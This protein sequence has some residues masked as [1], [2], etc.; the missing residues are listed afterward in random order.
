MT[1]ADM[2]RS[3]EVY[4]QMLIWGRGRCA[5]GH[6]AGMEGYARRREWELGHI[7]G[8]VVLRL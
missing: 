3:A 8:G 6:H 1:D 5:S 7:Q 2:S 4:M